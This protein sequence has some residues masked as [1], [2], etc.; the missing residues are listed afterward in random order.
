MI[1]HA[2]AAHDVARLLSLN[3]LSAGKP[4][5]LNG[6]EF[7]RLAALQLVGAKFGGTAI[8][9]NLELAQLL[10]E[11]TSLR[12]DLSNMIASL[13]PD[14]SILLLDRVHVLM[15]PQLRVNPIDLLCRVARRRLTCVSWPG[16]LEG[17][18]LR[19]ANRNHPEYFDED[20]SRVLVVDLTNESSDR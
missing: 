15:L 3:A 2:Q 13:Q 20:S 14:S 6:S 19:Y 10:M 12:P 1:D 18:R 8:N 16:L 17:G 4:V 11:E 9:L 5:F 7:D